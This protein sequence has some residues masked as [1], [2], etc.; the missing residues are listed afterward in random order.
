VLLSCP[1]C[2]PLCSFLDILILP[3]SAVSASP[4]HARETPHEY[5]DKHKP[6]CDP[7]KDH[8]SAALCC[9]DADGISVLV[10]QIRSLY[11]DTSSESARY[12]NSQESEHG[13]QDV[14]ECRESA[15]KEDGRNGKKRRNADQAD[16][17]TVEDEG[18]FLCLV[19]SLQ[20]L[21][22]RVRPVQRGEV[23][24]AVAAG[25]EFALE[26]VAG[27]ELEEC[28]AVA[29]KS[30]VLVNR[31][32][33]NRGICD[34]GRGV[35]AFAKVE[36]MRRVKVV[37]TQVSGKGV[38]VVIDVVLNVCCQVVEEA[39]HWVTAGGLSRVDDVLANA[40]CVE[41]YILVAVP[42]AC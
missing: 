9:R 34:G 17:D 25:I 35:V 31:F 8:K 23:D 2:S 12:C 3:C 4:D 41:L 15:F 18:S 30:D 42:V 38:E 24:V 27:V 36:N 14:D 11:S 37:D 39:D 1:H 40:R 26:S 20:T 10:D 13:N 5:I 7:S 28:G 16:A 33:G 19:Q 29:A 32:H 21:V 22:D 6:G